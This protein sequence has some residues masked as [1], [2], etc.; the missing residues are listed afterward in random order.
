MTTLYVW[1]AGLG[2]VCLCL[3]FCV[4]MLSEKLRTVEAKLV[5]LAEKYGRNGTQRIVISPV[6]RE[7]LRA[8][9]AALTADPVDDQARRPV[10]W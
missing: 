3:L 4:A 2:L 1:I 5:E 6:T 7:Q 8:D 10:G 9:F